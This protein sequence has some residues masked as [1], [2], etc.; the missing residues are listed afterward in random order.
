LED[1]AG[2]YNNMVMKIQKQEQVTDDTLTH[3]ENG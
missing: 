2:R 1:Q 3:F